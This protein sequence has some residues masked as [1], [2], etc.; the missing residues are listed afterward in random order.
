MVVKCA[1]SPV[2]K[3]DPS[4]SRDCAL[5][6]TVVQRSFSASRP[7][8]PLPPPYPADRGQYCLL[9]TFFS[10]LL[11]STAAPGAVA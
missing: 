4:D 10:P 8:S 9:M 11:C 5:R 2:Q 3:A 7:P 6:K 1:S